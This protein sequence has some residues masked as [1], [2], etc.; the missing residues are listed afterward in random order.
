MTHKITQSITGYEVVKDE[1]EEQE[2][3]QPEAEQSNIMS[4]PYTSPLMT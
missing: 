1:V 3:Q 4:T 2:Q